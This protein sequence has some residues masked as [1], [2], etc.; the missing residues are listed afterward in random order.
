MAEAKQSEW[1]QCI[2]KLYHKYIDTPLNKK[3]INKLENK[4]N[5]HSWFIEDLKEKL[6]KEQ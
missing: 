6:T 2:D 1:K 5:Y 3:E 4:E